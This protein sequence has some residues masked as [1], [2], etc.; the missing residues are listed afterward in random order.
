MP[1]AF[2]DC[3]L[4]EYD[5]SP[6]AVIAPNH[7]KLGLTFPR[8]AVFAFLGEAVDHYASLHG[9]EV[10]GT[11]VSMTKNYPIY[12]VNHRGE[13][14]CVCQAPVGAP[15]ATQ[16]LDWLIGYGVETI[17]AV[18]S[19]GTLVDLPENELV[20]PTEALRDEGTSYHYLPPSRT[21]KLSESMQRALC[22]ALS[23][24][25]LRFSE[26]M[27]W[28]T[29]AF[30]RETPTR[31]STRRSEG[32]LTV[33]MECAALA[34]CAAF[35]SVTFGQLLYTADSLAEIS[36]YD[37]RGWGENSVTYALH[38]CLDILSEMNLREEDVHE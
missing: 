23:K 1:F 21:V 19:C 20:V 9:A 33:E 29:D 14:L 8:K 28:T 6:E 32:C 31:V 24:R 18:G 15:A 2:S 25:K 11:F 4:L 30:F 10:I 16:L 26:G 3:P 37:E 5:P 35:R 34:A 36:A 22:E 38:L 13:E 7:E 12:R 27:T 17:L